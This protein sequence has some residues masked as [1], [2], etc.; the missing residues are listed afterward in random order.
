MNAEPTF[1]Q[2]DQDAGRDE[3]TGLFVLSSAQCAA[4]LN[5]TSVGRIVF[6]DGEYPIAVP[7][8]FAWFENSVVFR[9]GEGQKLRAATIEQPVSFE[10][11]QIDEATHS[12]ASVIVKGTARAV[13]DWAEQ[14]E[15][16]QLSVRPWQRLPWRHG[17]IRIDPVEVTGRKLDVR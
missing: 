1:L 17:W 11:D 4:V 13:T 2:T 16:E 12:G 9:T 3:R 8:N 5:S 6:V 15:L 10:V 7:V 14:E